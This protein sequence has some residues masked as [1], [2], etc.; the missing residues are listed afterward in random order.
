MLIAH[1]P[2]KPTTQRVLQLLVERG[3]LTQIECLN[4]GGGLRLAAR[5]KEIRDAY[6]ESAVDTEYE[7]SGAARYARYVWRGD[8]AEQRELGL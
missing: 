8:I 1:E 6:G 2:L 5:V 4:A 3:D 7:T